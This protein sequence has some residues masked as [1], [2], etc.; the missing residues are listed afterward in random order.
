MVVPAPW[1]ASAL[2]SPRAP[3]SPNSRSGSSA[4]SAEYSTPPFASALVWVS[5]RPTRNPHLPGGAEG[6]V[7][8]FLVGPPP[9]SELNQGFFSSLG[10][11]ALAQCVTSPHPETY[12]L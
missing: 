11:R 6:L 12:R 9:S 10:W 8:L 4:F 7:R 5:Q 2:G 1:E 3:A